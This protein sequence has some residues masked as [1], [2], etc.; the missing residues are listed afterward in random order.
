VEEIGLISNYGCRSGR[1]A[2]TQFAG[3]HDEEGTC[4]LPRLHEVAASSQLIT[5]LAAAALNYSIKPLATRYMLRL[6][7]VVM[8][9]EMDGPPVYIR[10]LSE[11]K[12]RSA[13]RLPIG[14]R[15]PS[16]L[17]GDP[18][19]KLNHGAHPSLLERDS[20]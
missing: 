7:P 15:A 6:V 16:P 12:R 8:E 14:V 4:T 1:T 13:E 5:H 2:L 10:E 9:V 11:A 20:V 18:M 3:C 19:E 17:R